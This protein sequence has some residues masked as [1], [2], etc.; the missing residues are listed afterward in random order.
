MQERSTPRLHVHELV[1]QTATFA[2]PLMLCADSSRKHICGVQLAVCI[3][4]YCNGEVD[5]NMIAAW[6]P[7]QG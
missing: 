7:L 3:H 5:V 4:G 1:G 2:S 6:L